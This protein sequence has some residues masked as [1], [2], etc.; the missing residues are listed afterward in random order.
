MTQQEINKHVGNQIRNLRGLNNETLDDM[1]KRTSLDRSR[2]NRLE[3]GH[4]KITVPEL[5]IF[6]RA[7]NLKNWSYFTKGLRGYHD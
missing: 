1:Q 7:Y 4:Q 5:D 6:K 2:L 3:L